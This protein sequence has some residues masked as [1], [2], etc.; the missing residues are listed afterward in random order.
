MVDFEIDYREFDRAMRELSFESDRSDY[1]IV[2]MNSQT[3]TK[4]LAW[5]TPKD[6]GAARAGFW[7]AWSALDLP[8]TPAG[9]TFGFTPLE[10]KSKKRKTPRSYVPDGWVKDERRNAGD[11]G[12][13]FAV[14]THTYRNGKR[15]YYPYILNAKV[16]FWGAGLREAGF[17]FGRAYE[18]LLKKH[19][20]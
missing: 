9:T 4:A 17:K 6:T 16:N 20:A 13:S 14:K 10:I 7:P 18:K 11:P 1:E 5:N 2:T 12:F 19:S 3:L 8:G 15:V